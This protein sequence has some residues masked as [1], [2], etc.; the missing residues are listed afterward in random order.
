MKEFKYIITDPEGMHA[1]PATLFVKEASKYPCSILLHKEGR[2]V[3][4][5]RMFAVM[6][7]G[8]KQGQE[9][10][11]RCEGEQEEAAAEA[12]NAFMREHL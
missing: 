10:V 8:I 7:L 2:E 3:D 11:I 12:M 1:R 9:V 6:S 5:K 4:A